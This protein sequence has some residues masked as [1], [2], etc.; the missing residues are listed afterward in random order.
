MTV[1]RSFLSST[2]NKQGF[3]IVE[4]LIVVIVIAILATVSIVSYNNI[5]N[6]ARISA[7]KSELSSAAKK[8]EISRTESIN[9]AYPATLDSAGIVLGSSST[10]QGYYVDTSTDVGPAYCIEAS[11]TATEQFYSTNTSAVT[12]GQCADAHGLI[13]WWKFNNSVSDASSRQWPVASTGTLASIAGQNGQANG[14]YQLANNTNIMVPSFRS[15]GESGFTMSGWVY[16]QNNPSS[17]QAYFG[18]RTAN[19]HFYVL[20]LFNSNTLECRV[21]PNGWDGGSFDAGSVTITPNSWNHVVLSYN[22]SS[23]R[24]YVNAQGGSSTAGTGLMNPAG[25]QVN[26]GSDGSNR[27]LGR[28]DDVRMYNRGLTQNEVEYLFTRGAQ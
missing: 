4:L 13:G 10:R 9:Q 23:A 28:I 8:L 20:Q 14:G 2:I 21:G 16:P 24:C 3:T 17:H 26:I 18:M 7:V 11:A 12:R 19:K 6:N 22:G 5:T 25:D 1:T 15:A 27:F